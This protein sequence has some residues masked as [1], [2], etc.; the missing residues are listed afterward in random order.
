MS[1]TQLPDDKRAQLLASKRRRL[2]LVV[3]DKL[4]ATPFDRV[5]VRALADDLATVEGD[6]DAPGADDI[7]DAERALRTIHLP[8]LAD[9]DVIER[10][11][12]QPDQNGERIVAAVR[13]T[14]RAERLVEHVGEHATQRGGDDA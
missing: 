5:D 9:A 12:E 4:S 7:E 3:F 8:R 13:P 2:L 1:T 10:V 14:D 11:A 6:G